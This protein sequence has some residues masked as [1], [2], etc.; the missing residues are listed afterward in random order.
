[1]HTNRMKRLFPLALILFAT[2]LPVPSSGQGKG[3][4]PT[5]DRTRALLRIESNRTTGITIVLDAI[6]PGGQLLP[7]LASRAIADPSTGLP[8][9]IFTLAIP[10]DAVDVRADIE[11][12]G[13][14]TVR[15]RAV[16]AMRP[17]A[18]RDIEVSERGEV[19]GFRLVTLRYRLARPLGAFAEI[20]RAATITVRWRGGGNVSP[21]H[22]REAGSAAE[23]MRGMI[24]NY[25][26]AVHWRRQ[27]RSGRGLLKAGGWGMESGAVVV[28]VPDDGPVALTGSDLATT[29]RGSLSFARIADLRLRSRTAPIPFDVVDVDADGLLGPGDTLVFP[30]KR[31]PSENGLDFFDPTTDTN[32]YVLSILGTGGGATLR[33]TS[34]IG[35]A[36]T[37][38]S[39]DARLH[40]EEDHVY[41][42]GRTYPEPRGDI[43]TIHVTETV[44]SEGYYWTRVVFPTQVAVAFE[45]AP[46]YWNYGST[47]IRLRLVGATDTAHHFRLR[48]NGI[49]AGAHMF[50]GFTDTMVVVT[51]PSNYLV[52]GRNE[53]LITPLAPP[54][55]TNPADWKAPDQYYLDY[56]EARGK[57]IP[58]SFGKEVSVVLPSGDSRRLV[59]AG[60]E[61]SPDD[62]VSLMTRAPL[63]SVERGFLFR[64]S[65]RFFDVG[66]RSFP[67]F[68]AHVDDTLFSAT[69][70]GLMLVEVDG[71][72]GAYVR[73]GQYG[74]FVDPSAFGE[75][76]RFIE[77]VTAGNIILAGFSVGAGVS[78]L[79]SNLRAAFESLGS[80]RLVAGSLFACSWAFAAR[81]GDPSTA[82]E[83]FEVPGE[84]NNGVTLDAF[85]R[86]DDDGPVWRGSTTVEGVAGEE[87][88]V[89]ARNDARLRFHSSDSLALST[90]SAD[91]LI[92][93]H[94][95]FRG[96]A[97]RLADHRR[98]HDTLRV[99]VVDIDIVYD[100][101]NH[102]VKSPTALRRFL[103]YADSNWVEPRPLFVLLFGDGTVDP[104]RRLKST[105]GADY[106]PIHGIPPADYMYTVSVGD[107]TM[108]FN[109]Y[110]GRLPANT[111]E[112]AEWLVDKLLA[113]DAYPPAAWQRHFVFM[114][115]GNGPAELAL[116]RDEDLRLAQ[117]YVLTPLFMGDTSMIFRTGTD[118]SFPDAIDG[119]WAR[120]ALGRGT[121]L[122]SFSGHGASKVYD[123]DFGYPRQLDNAD[124]LFVLG[125]FSCQ[126]GAFADGDERGRNEDWLVYPGTGAVAA[127][128]GT[129]YSFPAID[130]G[131]KSLLWGAMTI[132]G[133]RVLGEVF[134]SSK[135]N[136][137]FA[138][139][140][141][142]WGFSFEGIKS[143]NSLVMY[144][145]LGDPSMRLA[146]R[147]TIEL[148]FSDLTVES[149]SGGEPAPGD[150]IVIVKGRLWNVG[151]LMEPGD[152]TVQIV[153]T[154]IDRSGRATYDT[155]TVDN[156]A[157]WI[158]FTT[159][160]SI[161]GIPGEYT[162]RLSA[163]P[164]VFFSEETYRTDNDTTL[165]IRLRGNQPL[166]LEPLLYGRTAS[167]DAL[168][169]RLLNP[170]T[171]GG[172]DIMLDTSTAFDPA[173]R[174]TNATSGTMFIDELTT[175]WSVDIPVGLRQARAF[176]WRAVSTSGDTAVARLF[177]YVGSFTVEVGAAPPCAY[178]VAGAGQLGEGTIVSLRNDA[179][180]VGPGYRDVPIEVMS[181]GQPDFG[182]KRIAAI[183]DGADLFT[184]NY[185]GLNVLVFP[186][187][188]DRPSAYGKFAFYRQVQQG[189]DDIDRFLEM[190]DTV[191]DGERVVV[192]A[193]G[194]SFF[195]GDSG[196]AVKARLRSIGAGDV[197]DSLVDRVDSYALIGGKGVPAGLIDEHRN[198]AVLDSVGRV[199]HPAFARSTLRVVAREGAYTAP[200][201][202]PAR[203]WRTL[204]L[205]GTGLDRTSSTLI[206]LQRDGTRDTLRSIVGAEGVD[207]AFVSASRYPWLVLNVQFQADTTARLRALRID[208]DPTPELAIV[209]STAG[210]VPDSVL[211]G[212]QTMFQATVVNLTRTGE[213]WE[214]EG[215]LQL[216]GTSGIRTVDS[217]R[218]P[219][220]APRDSFRLSIPVS[221][222]SLSTN[223]L[224][225]FDVNADQTPVEPYHQTNTLERFLSV[226]TDDTRPRI[227]LYADGQRLMPGD[228]V[229]P[230]VEL[231][232]RLYDNSLLP[233]D[234]LMT[235]D[236]LILD[237]EIVDATTTGTRWRN[238]NDGDHRASFFYKP[239]EPLAEGAHEIKV[240]VNDASGNPDTTD[241][242][243]FNVETALRLRNVVNWPN[244]F[245]RSTTFTFM[246]GGSNRPNEGEI[247]IYT[248]SGRRIKTIPLSEADLHIGFN[249]IEW[250]GRDADGDLLA[251]GVY[252]YRIRVGDGIRAVEV[253]EKLAVIR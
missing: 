204:R 146:L 6:A 157:R 59:I 176:W 239:V 123:L 201:A 105:I 222:Q 13:Y 28:L 143:R 21:L 120:R 195:W 17:P 199:V 42:P 107:S 161:S 19:R 172:V 131:F 142:A 122:A 163:D 253:I 38:G 7:H 52:N 229:K 141:E 121:L 99:H 153:A 241:F 53:I 43:T 68:I 219:S 96:Q 128:G 62:A 67:G 191:R 179:G 109:S 170:S 185:D 49:D 73:Q 231:E 93:T 139:L 210:F 197:I 44:Q 203:A 135:Y 5:T 248:V 212:D 171:G 136:G 207:L 211:Q 90:N 124:R 41:Y 58:S 115:G 37:L 119:P 71:R 228:Y 25:D 55:I 198:N 178:M 173:S 237:V 209:P 125:T 216:H 150:S 84:N 148:T 103:S 159:R 174:I 11:R 247:A 168:T 214:E 92:V 63:S 76:L 162:A 66:L 23:A 56:I 244:P 184:I 155:V 104:A 137:I 8:Q 14:D 190:I 54:W 206:G 232:V 186:A 194:P 166:P 160:I 196:A 127:V 181:I 156:L 29:S 217:I 221:T 112:E 3:S 111:P 245:S 34:G 82:I 182:A 233:L 101:F 65:S 152:T 85:I 151:R 20:P 94:P 230:D 225:T 189:G 31:N 47:E 15:Y 234:S 89:G 132:E 86:D 180:G 165:V 46:H 108:R 78:D 32:A 57:F 102:G 188:D 116:H 33:R 220:I 4:A 75:A 187:G 177:P 40:F 213:S 205:E 126:T 36:P 140:E 70:E 61:V 95:A 145:L 183:V 50:T 226:T 133:R 118:L 22:S 9:L 242:V 193:S 39:T 12:R 249:T 30:G 64:L 167:Y 51:V 2:C 238:V 130:A 35:D 26:Q 98:R 169:I 16:R 252:L 24:D 97:E 218:L 240:F 138:G 200:T 88:T 69:T 175:T 87:F 223:A 202:G 74:T 91:L 110:I 208:F 147:N 60:F 83:A 251:N 192:V 114:S 77:E 227:V 27:G 236:K 129:S 215:R 48:V 154:I 18:T 81:K 134:T 235:V 149:E 224:F 79:P 113:Y 144:S 246:L 164:G 72:S 80:Q 117:E 10:H 243:P 158:D 106:I 250:D 1:M 100:E 45:C